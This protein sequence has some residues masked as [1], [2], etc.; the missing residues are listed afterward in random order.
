[1][2]SVGRGRQ[3]GR[4]AAVASVADGTL[5][6]TKVPEEEGSADGG[7]P[8]GPPKPSGSER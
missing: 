8:S 7:R 5:R 4:I 1:M 6:L 2:S 3:S